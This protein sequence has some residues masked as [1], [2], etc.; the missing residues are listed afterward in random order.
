MRHR[1]FLGKKHRYRDSSMDQ[2]FDNQVEPQ[3]DEP[4]KMSYGHKV[5]DMVKGINIEFG[6]KK[7]VEEDGTKTRK[8][9]KQGKTEDGGSKA[10][11]P[12]RTFQEAVVFLQVPVVLEGARYAPY[13][14]L[15]GPGEE[16]L[17]EHDRGPARH[18][19]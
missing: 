9:R 14:R 3:T 2:F 17:R 8:K 15:H 7:K 13:R 11:H 4:K 5:F 19:D 10:C 18:Q 6:K 16:C 1:R 12:C